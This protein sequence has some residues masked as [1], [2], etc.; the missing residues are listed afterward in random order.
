M[1]FFHKMEFEVRLETFVIILAPLGPASTGLI[2][3][4]S[5]LF[6]L[7]VVAVA[8]PFVFEGP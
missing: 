1:Q 2:I 5:N 4:M 7:F 6:V 8:Y 3:L